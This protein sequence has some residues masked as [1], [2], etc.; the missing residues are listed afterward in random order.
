MIYINNKQ[1]IENIKLSKDN[2]YILSDFDNTLTHKDSFTSWNVFNLNKQMSENYK[3]E[4]GILFRDYGPLENAPNISENERY[5]LMEE[6]WNKHLE[7]FM[8]YN[9]NQN[10]IE[11]A[12]DNNYI[13][14]KDGAIDFIEITTQNDIPFIVLS[15]GIG[16]IIEKFFEN[17]ELE[18]DNLQVI[19][20]FLEFDE[21]GNIDRLPN[22]II[23]GMNKNIAEMS[24][25]M[26]NKI[27]S[28][29]YKILIGDTLGDIHMV[30]ENELDSTISIAFVKDESEQILNKFSKT[31]DIILT[32]NNNFN[33]I[34]EILNL[35]REIFYEELV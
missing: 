21:N 14:L 18:N 24:N 35:R 20:N 5:K 23:H 3:L 13:F 4:S 15:G 17:L 9:L 12:I 6:W 1:K 22:K 30:D 27:D 33:D 31:F 2:F 34:M 25:D 7:L 11:Q 32:G 28:K 19:S 10:F 29:R 26:K 16:N 8:K